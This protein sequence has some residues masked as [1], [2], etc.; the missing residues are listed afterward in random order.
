[1]RS[2]QCWLARL[3]AL[4]LVLQPVAAHAHGTIIGGAQAGE[5][6]SDAYVFV[7]F[8]H[9]ISALCSGTVVAPTVVMTAGH[10]VLGPQNSVYA[11]ARFT[12]V[13]GAVS[14]SD[15]VA[16]HSGVTK[17]LLHPGFYLP[18]LRDDVALLVLAVPT[19]APAI[20]LARAGDPAVASSG[21]PAWISGWGVTAMTESTN[22]PPVLERAQT[23]V[24]SDAFCR[25]HQPLRG[26]VY[27]RTV[28]LC[29]DDAALGTAT[30]HGDSGG[31]LIAFRADGTP[32]EIGITSWGASNCSTGTPSYF[33]RVSAIAG[34]VSTTLA[35]LAATT[36][37]A[38]V[39]RAGVLRR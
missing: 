31:P 26:R 1:M 8:G 29:T 5:A 10:C 14:P 20:E 6:A 12:V 4:A 11:T 34:W 9:G 38:T 21:T 30:C 33:A 16:P 18:T 3:G 2:W 23:V 22:A 35:N 36:P 25:R 13:T 19:S 32:V 39:A 28:M 24:R 27:K 17:I 7:S 15:P 37:A